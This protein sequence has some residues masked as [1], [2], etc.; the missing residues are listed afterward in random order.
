MRSRTG[1][2]AIW[3]TA[4]LLLAAL[5]IAALFAYQSAQRRRAAEQQLRAQ[6]R[7][8]NVQQLMAL[9]AVGRLSVEEQ[10][11]LD[12]AGND[13]ERIR[14]VLVQIHEERLANAGKDLQDAEQRKVELQGTSGYKVYADQPQP[15]DLVEL[16]NQD[17]WTATS[18]IAQYADALRRIRAWQPVSYED[19]PASWPASGTT[20]ALAPAPAATA[21]DKPNPRVPI[22]SGTK[23]LP[24]VRQPSPRILPAPK[25]SEVAEAARHP[26]LT[27]YPDQG[28][29]EP[30]SA[31]ADLAE[32]QSA[33]AGIRDTLQRWAQAM[34]LNDPRAEAA[35]YAPHMDRYFLRTNVDKAF[36]Q[37]D[38][39]AYLGRGNRTASFS[40]RDVEIENETDTTADVRLVK[41][42]TWAQSTSGATHMLIRSQ[43]WLVRTPD[44][45]KITGERDFR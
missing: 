13:P 8:A 43:L 17:E 14:Q 15:K 2:N 4:A 40:L 39:A 25:A 26:S 31:I 45:W 35:E 27:V 9:S 1:A 10:T 30:R 41:D 34:T 6:W 18:A 33:E 11:R 42:V 23:G 38:K 32:R 22:A 5:A 7:S 21:G 24:A 37:A 3:T 20:V 19:F 44:G 29:P 36:V 28:T 12:R 16:A